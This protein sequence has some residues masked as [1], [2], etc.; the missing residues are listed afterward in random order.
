LTVRDLPLGDGGNHFD[1]SLGVARTANG[2]HLG[3]DY[4]TG[5][6]PPA[7]A[8]ELLESYTS[9]LHTIAAT[10][11]AT[12]ADLLQSTPRLPVPPPSRPTA[13]PHPDD[14]P[15]QLPEQPVPPRTDTE[16]R[17]AAA[18]QA[19]LDID[20]ISIHDNFFT[21]G[22]HSL[23]AIQLNL[24]L[25]RE[26]D[27]DIPLAQLYTAPTIAAQAAR[28]EA[29]SHRPAPG[30]GR[31]V[32]PLGGT[33]GARPLVLVHPV[34]GTLFNYLAL[35]ED[36]GAD[37]QAFGVQ[38][39][40]GD[41]DTGATDLAGLARLYADEL[42]PILGGAEPVVAGWSAGGVL[43]HELA[44]ALADR[45]IGVHRLVLVDSDP[46]LT[47]DAAEYQRDI[48][49]L[50]ALRR[51]VLD[52][53]PEPLLR[54]DEADRLFAALGVD[55]AAIAGL[56]GPT[57]AALMAF[58]RDMF[59]G[60]AA[61]RPAVFDGPADLV[62]ARGDGDADSA[63]D[64]AVVAAWRELTGSLQVTHADGD[65]FEILRRPWVK[66]IADAL[67]GSTIAQTGK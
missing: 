12:V 64:R 59:A 65:H 61:H 7:A 1:L 23:L 2:L 22:G 10:P 49:T 43:A 6:L 8:Q 26:F 4:S 66:A 33:P 47:E 52:H 60:L 38:G 45:G 15:N 14:A 16:Q 35:V 37:F 54:F 31:S 20:Q 24:E 67:R 21:L 44:R 48:D 19:V 11:Q 63:A 36:A 57:L 39:R 18:W 55:P 3:M 46:R 5:H 58:W 30:G 27:T 29:S 32:V 9:L 40:I 62:L 41:A 13:L 50:D 56:D 28:I 17:I 53:G 34:G 51:E 42:I 25:S